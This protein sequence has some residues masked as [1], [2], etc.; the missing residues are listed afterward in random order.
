LIQHKLKRK[1]SQRGI[2]DDACPV[3]AEGNFT[4]LELCFNGRQRIFTYPI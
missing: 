1:Y 2:V 4:G 3:V